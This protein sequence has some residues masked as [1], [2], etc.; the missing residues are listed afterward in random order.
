[1]VLI[2]VGRLVWMMR[3]AKMENLFWQEI[4]LGKEI[5]ARE[6]VSMKAGFRR[7]LEP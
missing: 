7:K 5:E 1:V 3:C 4:A 2:L 6:Y